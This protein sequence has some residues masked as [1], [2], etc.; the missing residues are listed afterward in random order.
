MSNEN[1]QEKEGKIVGTTRTRPSIKGLAK[2]FPCT[3]IRHHESYQ[4]PVCFRLCHCRP[5]GWAGNPATG[6]AY[7]GQPGLQ[8]RNQRTLVSK[9]SK[10]P[11]TSLRLPWVGARLRAI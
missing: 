9:A 5:A 2:P 11:Q 8:S 4:R 7:S 10:P 3:P 1:D 6:R